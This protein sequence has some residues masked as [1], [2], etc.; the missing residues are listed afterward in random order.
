MGSKK[1]YQSVNIKVLLVLAVYLFIHL[2]NI[3]FVTPRSHKGDSN[4]TYIVKGKV[5]N[6]FRF[7]RAAS[8][9][10]NQN[11]IST[12]RFALFAAQF[13]IVLLLACG[14][15]VTG[16][17]LFPAPNRFL[18]DYHYAFLRFRSIKIWSLLPRFIY[19]LHS[20]TGNSIVHHA[21]TN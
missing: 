16:S 15:W 2:T 21:S 3:F 5:K 13:F 4:H 6:I 19:L 12:N 8:T 1:K 9:I 14:I 18:P 10:V 7:Q 17:K 11:N 20:A